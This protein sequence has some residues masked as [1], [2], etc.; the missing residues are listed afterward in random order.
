MQK[1]I[2]TGATGLV[3]SRFVELYGSEFEIFNL[4]LATGVDITNLEQVEE[5]VKTHPASALIHLA[6]FTDTAKAEAELGDKEGICYRVNVL[7]TKNIAETCHKYNIHLIHISTDFVFDGTKDSPYVEND[8]VSPLGWYGTTK[9]MAETVVKEV[10]GTYAIARLSYPY[11]ANFDLKPDL[12]VKLRRGIESGALP[13]QFSDTQITPTFVD[14][15]AKGFA[16]IATNHISGI[17]HLV[18]NTSLS[19]YELAQKVATI[20][21]F[22]PSRVKEG[23]LTEYLKTNPRPFA[24]Y[25]RMSNEHTSKALGITF[26]TIDSGLAELLKQQSL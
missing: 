23:N 12:I 26:H 25:G 17:Y 7:G 10:G 13:P 1:I 4:D 14:D 9:A 19:P 5:F 2:L 8:P 21:G 3:G 15:I 16:I 24:R 20:Y 11:R 6:A 22:D 18:G